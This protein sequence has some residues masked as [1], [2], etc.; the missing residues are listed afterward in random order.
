[1]ENK[2]PNPKLKPRNNTGIS[3][4][5][6]AGGSGVTVHI[7]TGYVKD[8]SH[9]HHWALIPQAVS[10][11]FQSYSFTLENKV[12]EA[13]QAWKDENA[14]VLILVCSLLVPLF[15]A[16]SYSRWWTGYS[17]PNNRVST[18]SVEKADGAEM[19][20]GKPQGIHTPERW[21]FPLLFLRQKSCLCSAGLGMN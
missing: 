17:S 7:C 15:I 4:K 12:Y 19:M 3:V 6:W 14:F 8:P 10:A 20:W 21:C 16:C 1:M 11:W 13:V 9:F 2:N 5:G 18:S